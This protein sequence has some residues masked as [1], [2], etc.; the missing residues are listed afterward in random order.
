MRGVRFWSLGNSGADLRR[1][2]RP[3]SWRHLAGRAMKAL[4]LPPRDIAARRSD[5]TQIPTRLI[6]TIE[7]GG[8]VLEISNCL[9]RRDRSCA[10]RR[11]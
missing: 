9:R 8:G 1:E 10:K 3:N 6:S 7:P 2:H 5:C 4:E 11:P